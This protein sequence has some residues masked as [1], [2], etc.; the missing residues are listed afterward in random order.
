MARHGLRL[1]SAHTESGG[2]AWIVEPPGTPSIRI[3]GLTLEERA[4]RALRLAGLEPQR[5]VDDA[6][7]AQP[8]AGEAALAIR[9]DYVID[10]RLLPALRD[11]PDTLLVDGPLDPR[12]GVLPIAVHAR[13]PALDAALRGLRTGRLDA[14]DP[15]L[16]ALRIATPGELV[17]SY[18][19]ALRKDAAPLVLPVIAG[20]EREIEARLFDASY[21]GITDLVTQWVWPLPARVV[22]RRLAELRVR[23]NTVTAIS[24]VAVAAATILFARG[25]YAGGLAFA[26]AMTFLDTV[27]GKL[28]RVTLQSSRFGHVLDH[29]LD[30]LHPPFWYLAW[31]LGLGGTPFAEVAIWACVVGYVVGRAI[32]GLFL[33]AF[34]FE[35]HCWK[36]V[37]ARMRRVT[38]RRNPNL[39][40][41]TLG[42]V[43]G[44]PD[45]GLWAVALWTAISIAFHSVRW[46]QAL[47]RRQGGQP[48]EPCA[49][50]PRGGPASS[51]ADAGNGAPR[52]ERSR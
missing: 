46:V 43:G 44:R 40:L 32:E 34:G 42:V 1:R 45:L 5:A 25:A 52:R 7:S 48:I 16:R 15:E 14:S 41:L 47:A 4:C 24:W 6:G 23:P 17:P 49:A 13:G 31:G 22:T 20:R 21:K 8:G 3:W 11:R 39:I 35:I 12:E 10:E 9:S 33:L 27:D 18:D 2:R 30:L 29:G 19:A 37:D 28:A 50:R 36:P 26:W 51:V 38:A